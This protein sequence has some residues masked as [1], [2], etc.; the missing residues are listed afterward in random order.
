MDKTTL[1]GKK[2]IIFDLGGVILNIDIGKTRQA[3]HDIGFPE[4]DQ[5]FGLGHADSFFKGHENGQVSDD[6]FIQQIVDK[7]EGTISRQQV[8]DAWNALILDFPAERI[9]YI[10]NL[11]GR[12]RLFLFSNTNG[13]HQASFS[14]L[15]QAEFDG[16]SMDELFE[17][18]YYSH[19][20]GFRKPDP[21]AFIHILKENQLQ[22]AETIFIDDALVNVEAARSLGI[23]GIH[24]RPGEDIRQLEL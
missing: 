1:T 3:F 22:P 11:K 24:L 16:A 6:Q 9:Q 4:I 7:L 18:A 8:I 12:Y 21:E 19:S 10:R 15:Y 2:A 23:V 17:K 13:I 20:A 5:L 14:K